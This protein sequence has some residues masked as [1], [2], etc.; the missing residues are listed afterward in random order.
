MSNELVA[1]FEKRFVNGPTICCE[2]RMPADRFHVT[3]LIGPSGSGKTTVLRALAGLERPDVGNVVFRGEKW[4]AA[5]EGVNLSPQQR[6]VAMLFQEYALF[7]HLTVSQNVGYGLRTVAA[8]ERQRVVGELLRQFQ[9][10]EMADR[11]PHQTSGG[12]Q[13]RIALAR[14]LARRP[15]L[16]L[17]DEPL[18]ALDTPLRDELRVRLRD[19]LAAFAVPVILVTHDQGEAAAVG[20]RIVTMEGG[21]VSSQG[22]ASEGMAK[23][24]ENS[25]RTQ[26]GPL[27]SA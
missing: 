6:N 13:Q 23:K 5:S 20:D 17:L 18:S 21:R 1:E 24:M 25:A 11:Y 26:A 8:S 16:L 2:L 10:T 7:S 4:F 15:R 27:E 9:L 3:V 12:Q 19:W 14:A 22:V